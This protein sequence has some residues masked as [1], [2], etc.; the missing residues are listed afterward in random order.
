MKK[1]LSLAAGLLLSSGVFAQNIEVKTSGEQAF[2]IP[3][4]IYGQFAE[5]LGRCIY[6]GIWVGEDSKIPNTNGYRTDLVNALKDLKIPVLRW[7]GGCF[8][9]T[10]YW[11]DGVG[12]KENRPQIKNVFWGGT[13]EDNSFGTKEFFDLCEMIGCKTYLSV[14]VG[15]GTVK[16]MNQWLEYIT[17]TEKCPSVDMRKADGREKPWKLDYIGI[18]NESWGCGGNMLPDFYSM[19]YRQYSGYSHL[20][21][22]GTNPFRVACGANGDDSNWTDVVM[23]Y[24]AQNCEGISLHY[25]TLPTDDWGPKG[26]GSSTDFGEDMYFATLKNGMRMDTIINKHLKIMEKYDAN[27]RVKL[28]VDEWGIW[29]D[30]LP[31][32]IEGHLYQQN[33]MRDAILASTTFDIFNSHADRIGMANIAQIV[34]VLQAMILT[35]G[36]KMVLTPT[37]H[38]FKMYSCHQN[39]KYIPMDFKS[40]KYEFNGQSIPAVNMTVSQK[41]NNVNISITNRDYKKQQTI[42]IDLSNL[43]V[44]K[45]A[46]AEI[47]TS[48]NCNDYNSFDEPNKV[49]VKEFKGAVIKK[50]QLIITLPALS[51][52]T[53]SLN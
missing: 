13:M 21:S 19:L 26:K 35:E 50:N 53:I 29:T 45:L 22:N 16:D 46:K 49:S 39:A 27:K 34:N 40:P 6:D 11:R 30:K 2:E 44:S 24:C 14:N 43:K 36:E 52:A 15:S 4:E 41:D 5:H 51:I 25:Y 47:L 32:S 12:P 31:G 42:T 37:Y 48:K 1:S 20:Y 33:T 7:P 17:G 8:A 3:A 18:G 38:V 10:Y 28:L 23:K 9:D